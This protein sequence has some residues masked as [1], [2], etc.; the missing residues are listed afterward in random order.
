MNTKKSFWKNFSFWAGFALV[1]I[2]VLFCVYQAR[3][4][5]VDVPEFGAISLGALIGMFAGFFVQ[6]VKEFDKRALYGAALVLTGGGVLGFMHWVSPTGAHEVWF[7][8]IGLLAGFG[9]GT[10]WDVVDPA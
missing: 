9:I 10:I 8:P 4:G 7:Y 5:K 6:E 2:P 3:A 1:A